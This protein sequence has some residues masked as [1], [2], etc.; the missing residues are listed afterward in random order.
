METRPLADA[1]GAQW[2]KLLFDGRD[3]EAAGIDGGQR[4]TSGPAEG[5]LLEKL[6]VKR[7]DPLRVQFAQVPCVELARTARRGTQRL[8]PMRR[9]LRRLRDVAERR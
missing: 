1:R 7:H 2:T 5:R 3:G 8:R 9:N 4:A 6:F